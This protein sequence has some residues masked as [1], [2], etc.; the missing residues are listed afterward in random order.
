MPLFRAI[1]ARLSRGQGIICRRPAQAWIDKRGEKYYTCCNEMR[2]GACR[3]CAHSVPAEA[4]RSHRTD[5]LDGQEASCGTDSAAENHTDKIIS[6]RCI[7]RK[8]MRFYASPNAGQAIFCRWACAL[9][10][11]FLEVFDGTDK[12]TESR[13]RP[14]SGQCVRRKAAPHF[15]P[16]PLYPSAPPPPAAQGG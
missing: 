4:P 16:A 15:P 12:R 8:Q 1:L 5:G 2:I 13:T 3:G 6:I 10:I 7:R 11:E 14:G 9:L